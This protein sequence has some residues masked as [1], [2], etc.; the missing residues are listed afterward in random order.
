MA[1]KASRLLVFRT[2]ATPRWLSTSTAT[3]TEMATSTMST[4]SNKNSLYHRL[5]TLGGKDA[6]VADTLDEWEKE[7]KPFKRVQII[8]SVKLLRKA[9]K[10]QHAIQI[11]DWMENSENKMN[12]A[13][14]AIRI[15]LL[16]KTEGVDS[17]EKYF[18]SL[19]GSAKTKKTYGALLNCYCK[20]KMLD[21]A[22][23]IFEKMREL[24][25]LSALNYNNMMS[26]YLSVGQPEKVRLLL[27]EME[28][29]NIVADLYTYNQL[30]NI[31]AALNDI[32]AVEGVLEKMKTNKV[33]CDW[34]TYGNLA[35]IYVNAGLIDKANAALQKLENMK[36]LHDWESFHTLIT[37]YARV[38]N[39]SGVNRA[40]ESLKSISPKPSTVSYVI[41]LLALSKLGD[42]GGLEKCFKEW[43]SGCST[44]DARVV[45]VI[46]ESH[47]NQNMIEEA[48]SIYESMVKRGA[49]PNLRTL[50]LFTNFYLK[51]HQMDLA[52][53]YLEM[54]A[55]KMKPEKKMWFPTDETVSIFLK[56][57]EEERDVDRAEKFCS[58]M[59]KIGR[60]DPKVSDSLLGTQI[61]A[62]QSEPQMHQ[63]M[64]DGTLD[65]P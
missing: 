42:V 63:Q 62:G 59:K 29:N 26:L 38:S 8:G 17:A 54:G 41:M 27:K 3:E 39:L 23:E 25:F 30:M 24:N 35:T 7:G 11:Y 65:E 10:Y 57:F 33:K 22:I 44:Y 21:K 40:W 5:L 52:L 4:K 61:A 12:D 9:K 14:R 50:D 60:L 48:E 2:M 53:K 15:D 43:E 1:N 32:D 37:L 58:I 36:N 51:R 28:E 49:G 56:Y 16:S 47:L 55:S 46:L 64:K 13:D 34:F 18:N 20:E 6:T 19:E 31:Y 45:N